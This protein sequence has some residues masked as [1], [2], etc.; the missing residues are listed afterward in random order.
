MGT[1]DYQRCHYHDWKHLVKPLH[2][3]LQH[4]V[5]TK[6]VR[7]GGT[8][9][10]AKSHTFIYCISG[11]PTSKNVGIVSIVV[12]SLIMLPIGCATYPLPSWSSFKA[13]SCIF[14]PKIKGHVRVPQLTTADQVLP[15]ACRLTT[16]IFFASLWL[17]RP[18]NTKESMMHLPSTNILALS[19]TTFLW[20]SPDFVNSQLAKSYSVLSLTNTRRRSIL[21]ASRERIPAAFAWTTRTSVDATLDVSPLQ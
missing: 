17:R 11:S 6:L 1:F 18:F 15:Q 8:H 3:S 12:G 7:K 4:P 10:E 13:T 21:N 16:W 19:V 5:N 20:M 2:F 14:K 9:M